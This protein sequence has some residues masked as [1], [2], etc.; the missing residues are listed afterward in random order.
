MA[1]KKPEVQKLR[2]VKNTTSFKI[3]VP[4]EVEAKIRHLCSRVHDVEWSG[5]LF[6]RA[7]GSMEDGSFKV[8]C[9][10]IFVMDIG[11]AGFTQY[12]ES[13]D[14]VD[15]MV[16]HPELLENGIYQGLIHSHNNMPTFFSGTD[17]GTLLSEGQDTVHFVSLIVNNAGKYTAGVTRRVVKE[18]KAEAHIKYTEDTHYATYQDGVI[19]LADAKVTEGDKEEVLK[20]EYIEWFNLEIEKAEVSQPFT[21]IDER[22]A[23]IK[24][25]KSAAKPYSGGY[26]SYGGYG[27]QPT[28]PYQQKPFPQSPSLNDRVSTSRTVPT[29]EKNLIKDSIK[30]FTNGFGKGEPK[31]EPKKDAVQLDLFG[32]TTQ[33]VND[34]ET[35]LCLIE[36]A[37]EN[38]I[39][40]LAYQLLTGSIIITNESAIDIEKWIAQMDTLFEKRF[41]SFKEKENEERYQDWLERFVELIIYE[42]DEQLLDRLAATYGNDFDTSDTSEIIAYD[43]ILFLLDLPDSY[44][45]ECIITELRTYLPDDVDYNLA[46]EGA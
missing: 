26:N 28:Y 27:Y 33:E 24:K 35:P 8:T 13:V 42:P 17:T 31:P 18:I 9:V 10:D 4:E 1:E 30:D 29:P 41:G 11:T 22:L 34:A 15:Y 2:L 25:N 45:K 46:T 43:L 38:L 16:Q 6:Y 39:K 12:D 20:D 19:S 21:E 3:V 23:E 36:K 32:G 5:T 7:E 44:C 14:V 40:S 37:D